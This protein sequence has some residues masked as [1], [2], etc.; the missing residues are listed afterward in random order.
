M[1]FVGGSPKINIKIKN[2][3]LSGPEDELIGLGRIISL[4]S[5]LHNRGLLI[6]NG[7]TLFA[8]QG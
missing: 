2:G 7:R 3:H 8:P 6:K 4:Q 1:L 5:I